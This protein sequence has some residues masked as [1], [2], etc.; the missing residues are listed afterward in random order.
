MFADKK[1]KKDYVVWY[2][3]QNFSTN[4]VCYSRREKRTVSSLKFE[5]HTVPSK[6]MQSIIVL[7]RSVVVYETLHFLYSFI[8]IETLFVRR[9]LVR[10]S[11][12]YF[13]FVM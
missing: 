13:R 5:V 8:V 4:F 11:F 7:S 2:G 12:Y 1:K 9:R 10:D 6:K 3:L